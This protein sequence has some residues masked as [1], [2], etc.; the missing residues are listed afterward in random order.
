MKAISKKLFFLFCF[1]FLLSLAGSITAEG[2]VRDLVFFLRRL[3]TLDHLPELEDSHTALSSTWDRTDGNADDADFKNIV[4]HRNILLNVDGPGCVHRIF[5]VADRYSNA[6][7]QIFL[8]N[9]PNPVFDMKAY[10]FL[11][12]YSAPIP[13]HALWRHFTYPGTHLTIPFSEHCLIQLNNNQGGTW[14]RY[15]QV[16]YSVYPPE[17]EVESF[18]WPLNS[19]ENQELE[20][21]NNVWCSAES[22]PPNCPAQWAVIRNVSMEPGQVRQIELD[23][24]GVVRQMRVSVKPSTPEVLKAI[25]MHI[26]WDGAAEPSVDVPLGYFFGH[27]DYGHAEDERFDSLLLGVT[28][29]EAYCCFPMP[30]SNGAV[31]SF[32]NRSKV[33][34][35][36]LSVRLD[37]EQ[38]ASLPENW[39]RFHA[40]WTEENAS[41]EDLDDLPHYGSQEARPAHLVLERNTG[42]GKYV[43]VLL[44]V[45]WPYTNWW[46]EGD[47]LIWTDEDSWPPSYHGTG[48]EEYFNSGWGWFERTANSGFVRYGEL[49]QVWPGN[50]AVYSFHLN[51]AFQFSSNVRVAVEVWPLVPYNPLLYPEYIGPCI[52]GSTAYWYALPAQPAGSRKRMI[53]LRL[54]DEG[55]DWVSRN[56]VNDFNGDCVVDCKDLAIL[57]DSW[58]ESGMWPP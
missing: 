12:Y 27:G 49:G 44:H 9:S 10:D 52:W 4:G 18:S 36:N 32:K 29:H 45:A 8:D 20:D 23:G 16:A 48:T 5:G 54:E 37:I 51:D 7:I 24:C 17:T 53:C 22:G 40:T 21:V 28:K 42:P 30:F 56:L 58:L 15:W 3:R 41:S 57:M 46:G 39:G 1:A 35:S 50:M 43:G 55:L 13:N 38:Y 25:G 34:V 31:F 26:T 47:W 19:E 33:K 14:G 2:E 11:N 6:R